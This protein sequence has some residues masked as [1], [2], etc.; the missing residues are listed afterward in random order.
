MSRNTT[1]R[2][3]VMNGG[4]CAACTTVSTTAVRTSAT[5]LTLTAAAGHGVVLECEAAVVVPEQLRNHDLERIATEDRIIPLHEVCAHAGSSLRSPLPAPRCASSNASVM[6]HTLTD[7]AT[8]WT[9][10]SGI[11]ASRRRRP[12]P[13]DIIA[14]I[15]DG[16]ARGC[17]REIAC[18]T[19]RATA[20]TPRDARRVAPSRNQDRAHRPES[21]QGRDQRRSRSA[22]PWS[23]L[24]RPA[25]RG[26]GENAGDVGHQVVVA[27]IGVGRPV[28]G[29]G[30]ASPP[31]MPSAR[32]QW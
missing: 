17:R 7:P 27:R 8:S 21:S 14:S 26:R 6:R 20:C 13:S 16:R 11:R 28:G 2:T 5:G 1:T 18:S 19:W 23:R 12:T 22:R 24:P 25:R 10:R 30:C 32:L 4:L 31:P 3:A 15:V 9:R 29:G